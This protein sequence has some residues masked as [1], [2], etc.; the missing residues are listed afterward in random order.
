MLFKLGGTMLR[1][2]QPSDAPPHL[3]TAPVPKLTSQEPRSKGSRAARSGGAGVGGRAERGKAG[4]SGFRGSQRVGVPLE[5]P[6][7]S[8]K[9]G[10]HIYIYTHAMSVGQRGFFFPPSSPFN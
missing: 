7:K 9:I 2:P 5:P 3:P 10:A 6:S 1:W 4:L 8:P